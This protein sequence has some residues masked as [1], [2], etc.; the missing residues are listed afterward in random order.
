MSCDPCYSWNQKRARGY[1]AGDDF[2]VSEVREYNS[3]LVIAGIT[4]STIW[5]LLVLI[6]YGIFGMLYCDGFILEH[7]VI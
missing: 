7:A 1:V 5:N 3:I 4:P 6:Y 2:C